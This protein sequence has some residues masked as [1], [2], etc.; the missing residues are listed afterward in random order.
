[1]KAYGTGIGFEVSRLNF[2]FETQDIPEGQVVSGTKVEIDGEPA[3]EWTFEE[4]F[5]DGHCMAVAVNNSSEVSRPLSKKFCVHK[6][7]I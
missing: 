3:P 1:M 2:S 4:S 6:V 5:L 7:V